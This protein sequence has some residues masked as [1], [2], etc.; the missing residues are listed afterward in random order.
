MLWTLLELAQSKYQSARTDKVGA[1]VDIAPAYRWTAA[2]RS[3][4]TEL[5]FDTS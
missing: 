1:S 4:Y 5:Y 2:L 3:P